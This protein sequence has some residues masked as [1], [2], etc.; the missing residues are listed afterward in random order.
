MKKISIA[1]II[2][3]SASQA[4]ASGPPGVTKAYVD[5]QAAITTEASLSGLSSSAMTGYPEGAQPLSD[6]LNYLTVG[7][8][9]FL[10]LANR[11]LT[12]PTPIKG[13]KY[14]ASPWWDPATRCLTL[15]SNTTYTA[16]HTITVTEAALTFAVNEI[17]KTDDATNPGPFT[18]TV[19]TNNGSVTTLTVSETVSGV[20]VASKT[21][22]HG[23]LYG[24]GYTG[25]VYFTWMDD[26]GNLILS[27]INMTG[28]TL[29]LPQG[30]ATAPVTEG[31]I[32]HNTSTDLNTI[33]DGTTAQ[34][35][36]STVTAS[37]TSAQLLASVT[38]ETGTGVLV[39]GTAP[40]FTTSITPATA[41]GATVGTA[42]L[43]FSDIYLADGGKVYF[44]NDQSVYLTPSAGTL[45]LTGALAVADVTND[46]HID[47]TNNAGGRAPTASA[48]EIYPDAGAFKVNMGGTE[49]TPSSF[50]AGGTTSA[51]D[52]LAIPI[53]AAYVA[54]TTGADAEALTL[55][56]GKPGQILNISLVVDGGGDG[57]LTPTTKSGFATIVFADAGDNASLMYIDDTVGWILMGTAGVAA[58]PVITQ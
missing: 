55:A 6:N 28:G 14:V 57:T 45:T 47:I 9:P 27:D 11:Q 30:T 26:Q 20:S 52:S 15:T 23:F 2:L 21:V 25:T 29:E 3:V 54:K 34:Q 22:I 1:I 13:H 56:N 10:T 39:F 12:A 35:L 58:P 40:S 31:G 4:F 36:Y 5:T 42:A 16:P 38:N 50:I 8:D 37:M 33:G 43:E 24:V 17:I 19:A 7:D 53:T 41:D 46:N 49:Y 48:Y 18:V 51:A 32:Y 44:Q